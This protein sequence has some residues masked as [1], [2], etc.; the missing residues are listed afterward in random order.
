MEELR[1]LAKSC[2]VDVLLLLLGVAVDAVV[3]VTVDFAAG[4]DTVADDADKEEESLPSPTAPP[5]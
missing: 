2:W 5:L 3:T 1:S 4:G